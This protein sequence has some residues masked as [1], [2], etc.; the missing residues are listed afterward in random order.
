MQAFV[1]QNSTGK[2]K[3]KGMPAEKG[4]KAGVK[5]EGLKENHKKTSQRKNAKQKDT[6][7]MVST[8]NHAKRI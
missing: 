7:K 2:V 6:R 8:E 4:A 1:V 5:T 3:R